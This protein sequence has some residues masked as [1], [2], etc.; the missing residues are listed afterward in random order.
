MSLLTLLIACCSTCSINSST[1]CPSAPIHKPNQHQISITFGQTYLM[2]HVT[3]CHVTCVVQ[4]VR[5][6]DKVVYAVSVNR[7]AE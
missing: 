6:A 3:V 7:N 5:P 1:F 4:S 2:G